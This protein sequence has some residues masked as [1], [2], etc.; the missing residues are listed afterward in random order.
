MS[1]TQA[2]NW[3]ERSKSALKAYCQQHN[4]Q[5]FNESLAGNADYLE[6]QVQK[7]WALQF[8]KAVKDG[9]GCGDNV[10]DDVN[11]WKRDNVPPTNE[12]VLAQLR[13][14]APSASSIAQ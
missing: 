2:Q 13:G 7:Y 8:K 9:Y 14:N 11:R 1:E 6:L 10:S 3:V 4:I 12:W 5:G